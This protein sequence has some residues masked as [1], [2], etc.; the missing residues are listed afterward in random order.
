MALT[1]RPVRMSV[2]TAGRETGPRNGS[3]LGTG[4]RRPQPAAAR[5]CLLVL[6]WRD[7]REGFGRGAWIPHIDGL[8]A[9]G[10][11]L[12]ALLA[13]RIAGLANDAVAECLPT[14]GR[15]R[16]PGRAWSARPRGTR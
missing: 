13:P 15:G 3:G 4:T 1:E 7:G 16:R 10:L 8:R 5:L 11:S 14:R 12:V 9:G 6:A 2:K